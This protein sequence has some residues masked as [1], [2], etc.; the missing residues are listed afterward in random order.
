MKEK[1]DLSSDKLRTLLEAKFIGA[2]DVFASRPAGVIGAISNPMD[3]LHGLGS[4]ATGLWKL[5]AGDK[6]DVSGVK[7]II[8]GVVRIVSEDKKAVGGR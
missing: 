4:I 2:K 3:W 7:D 5:L 1:P 6:A 8:G